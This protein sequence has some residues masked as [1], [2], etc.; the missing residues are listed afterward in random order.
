MPVEVGQRI[1][2]YE[3]LAQLGSGGMGRVYRVRNVI[4]NREEAMKI[5]LPDFASDPDLAAR[6]MTEI[7]TLAT[8]EHPGI[9]Q[10]RTAFQFQ[11]QFVMVMEY[12]EGITL[13]K[14][15]AQIRIPLDH[16]LDYT[17]Q[18][19][20][21]LSYAHSRGVTHRDI[22]PAN[23]MITT[24]GVVK[25]MDFGIAKSKEDLQ[26]T[27][28]G[29]TMGSVYYM[30]PEQIRGGTVDWRSDVYSLGV[31]VYEVLTGRKPFQA[32]TSYSVLDAQLNKM[33]TSP[34]D[35][36][37]ALP[38]ELNAIVMR[39]LEKRPEDRFQTAEEFRNALRTVGTGEAVA[40]R[41]A[42]ASSDTVPP[43]QNTA[44]AQAASPVTGSRTHSA[45]DTAQTSTPPP[46]QP[47]P[48]VPMPPP[49]ASPGHR[50]LWIGLGAGLALLAL[51]AV[52][53]VL[54]RIFATH[55]SQKAA[56]P[57][58][59]ID[60]QASGAV[61]PPSDSVAPAAV[62]PAG[63]EAA[64]T[65]ATQPTVTTNEPTSAVARPDGARAQPSTRAARART[66]YVAAQHPESQGASAN[67]ETSQ[68]AVPAT[69]AALSESAIREARDHYSNL[70]ARADAALSSLQ[71]LRREQQAQG[72]DLRGDIVAA[73]SRMQT[74][75]NEAQR[76]LDRN[77]L[78]TAA[79]YM[80][81]ADKEIARLEAFLGR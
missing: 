43:P 71:Q 15:A 19:L 27:R 31:T 29:T 24:H 20:A 18:V 7:R 55:A 12:V 75:L 2:D 40:T 79:N 33:P 1:G 68:A 34:R 25:L 59:A 11:G 8:L 21:A 28:P 58:A 30:S 57:S 62:S 81:R 16:A 23:I 49:G 26:L 38:P 67:P 6:F 65:G 78:T 74:D 45:I 13:E 35:L 52:G 54:P 77:E 10:L 64:G 9:A 48:P 56:P 80:D 22:K 70:Q 42:A 44:P 76:S 4:S 61:T 47:V 37:P 63:P 69:P 73:M 46:F 5:L 39:A 17:G 60:R 36:N 14:L 50:G 72:V 3:V 51:V 41:G 53:L 32:D 66:P